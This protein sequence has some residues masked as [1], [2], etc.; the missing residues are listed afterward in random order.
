[1]TSSGH[2]FSKWVNF[3]GHFQRVTSRGHFLV[4]SSGHFFP[5]EVLFLGEF[6]WTFLVNFRGHFFNSNE[7]SYTLIKQ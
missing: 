1:M 5:R 7:K 6:L 3:R 2:F 4:N